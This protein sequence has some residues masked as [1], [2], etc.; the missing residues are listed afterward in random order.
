MLHF[1][2]FCFIWSNFEKQV[3][4]SGWLSLA[5]SPEAEM[6]PRGQRRLSES[7]CASVGLL[8]FGSSSDHTFCSIRVS[9]SKRQVVTMAPRIHPKTSGGRLAFRKQQQMGLVPVE[10]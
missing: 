1:N 5:S 4:Q 7:P 10:N 9:I 3:L 2:L 8:L 6:S